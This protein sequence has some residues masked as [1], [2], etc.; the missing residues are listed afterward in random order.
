MFTAY[1]QFEHIWYN[2]WILFELIL[3]FVTWRQV[4]RLR[5]EDLQQSVP[6][7]KVQRDV[8]EVSQD[9]ADLSDR[10]TRFQKRESMRE[11][12]DV[13]QSAKDLQAEAMRIMQAHRDPF[14]GPRPGSTHPKAQLY[15]EARIH[16][17]DPGP[18]ET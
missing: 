4:K 6:F 1:P 9:L 18:Y 7:S 13:K 5:N 2:A 3:I 14:A 8:S 15:R 12:R 11:A 16:G 17:K 10:F